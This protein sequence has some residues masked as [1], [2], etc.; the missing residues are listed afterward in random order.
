MCEGILDIVN[1]HGIAFCKGLG[2]IVGGF[3]RQKRIA[4]RQREME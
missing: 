2:K 4:K 3:F 1:G